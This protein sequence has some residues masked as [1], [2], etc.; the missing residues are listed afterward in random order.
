M[1]SETERLFDHYGD[2]LR[3]RGLADR[4]ITNYQYSL[5]GFVG[6]LGARCLSGATSADITAYQIQLGSQK[7]SDSRIH[8]ATYALRG[9]FRFV[10]E[11]DDWDSARLPLR[12]EPKRL[13]VVLSPD[14]IEAILAATGSLKHRCAF[15]MCYGSGLRTEEMLQ[16]E[17]RHI[18]SK[19]MV[20]RVEQGKG[21]KDR[22]V[23]LPR[24]LLEILRECWKKYRPV[25]YVL[26]GKRPGQPMAATTVQRAFQ[27]ARV[28][29][30]I[31]KHVTPRSLRHAFATH[32]VEQGTP[33][34]VVQ[35]LLGHTSLN[36]TQIYTH[37]AC[38]WLDEV[39][40][41]LDVLKDKTPD[42]SPKTPKT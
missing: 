36:T 2:I 21:N 18:D 14:E 5:K 39:K 24:S 1:N 34:R 19:R 35:T 15:M 6:F 25:R 41:P 3:A 29:A 8:V 33:L 30:E 26:E 23:V 32:L 13:P 9:F 40:S 22:D 17:P 37:L 42:V 11:R 12:H 27:D 28:K 7:A 16:V 20:I 4:S 10:L 31:T 38:S